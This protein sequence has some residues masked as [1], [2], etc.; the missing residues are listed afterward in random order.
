MGVVDF[1]MNRAA[2]IVL[3]ALGGCAGQPPVEPVADPVAARTVTRTETVDVAVA[4]PREVPPELREPLRVA[5]PTL[6]PAG[7]GDY[8]LSLQD[9]L[10]VL[11]MVSAYRQHYMTCAG[12]A[13]PE[14]AK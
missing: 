14:P 11:R 9:A 8:G 12:F 10:R 1:L 3:C 13:S 7:Q 6:L 2:L 4:A 5:R